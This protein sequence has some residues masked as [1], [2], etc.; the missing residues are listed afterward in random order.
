MIYN[1][2]FLNCKRFLKMI[3]S[4]SAQTQFIAITHNKITMEAA[5]NL[6]GVTMA[7]PGISQLVGVRF[8][9]ITQDETSGEVLIDTQSATE[10]PPAEAD[11]ETSDLPPAVAERVS[12]QVNTE[13]LDT[14]A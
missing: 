10:E 12:S 3:G 6:Y 4:F 9:D 14:N 13:D 11:A 1:N 7:Q 8:S 2:Y 5:R